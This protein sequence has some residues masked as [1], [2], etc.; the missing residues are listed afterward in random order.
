MLHGRWGSW[1]Q[2][3]EGAPEPAAG[4]PWA[5]VGGHVGLPRARWRPELRWKLRSG[6]HCAAPALPA[7]AGS[8][9]AATRSVPLSPGPAGLSVLLPLCRSEACTRRKPGVLAAKAAAELGAVS[10]RLA[11]KKCQGS[12]GTVS[13]GRM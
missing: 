11:Q 2:L 8:E 6:P 3:R 7:A 9:R 13:I 5:G 10:K 12:G 1:D 4:W